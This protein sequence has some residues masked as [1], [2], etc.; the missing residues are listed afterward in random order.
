M[1]Q[2]V[3][4]VVRKSVIHRGLRGM[5]DMRAVGAEAASA[6]NA[7]PGPSGAS[8]AMMLFGQRL[9]LYGELYAGGEPVGHHPEGMVQAQRRLD[10]SRSG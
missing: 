7:R 9:K 1:N 4:T 2:T 8:A 3:R 10:A 6:I 5:S